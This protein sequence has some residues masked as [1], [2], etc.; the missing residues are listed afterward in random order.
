[1]MKFH[2]KPPALKGVFGHFAKDDCDCEIDGRRW[3]WTTMGD[4]TYIRPPA[5]DGTYEVGYFAI[6][7]AAPPI[8][9][10]PAPSKAKIE[11]YI[12]EHLVEAESQRVSA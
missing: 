12:Q 4:K 11:Q 6:E 9:A 7:K 2:A 8:G 5:L 3:S 1:M 10:C